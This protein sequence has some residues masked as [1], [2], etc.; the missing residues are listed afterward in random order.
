[1]RICQGLLFVP[2]LER[3]FVC[4]RKPKVVSRGAKLF[5]VINFSR[6]KK[7]MRTYQPQINTYTCADQVL[8]AFASRKRKISCSI[9]LRLSQ[10][11]NQPRVFIVRMCCEIKYRP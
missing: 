7:F 10:P 9:F 11:S 4:F 8:S 2:K 1:Y 6:C 5:A 3:L